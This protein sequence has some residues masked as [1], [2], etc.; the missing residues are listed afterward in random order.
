MSTRALAPVLHYLRHF[1]A[2]APERGGDDGQL[3]ERFSQGGDEAAFAAILKRY[4]PMVFGV[5]R[6]IVRDRHDAEDAF[7]ATFLLLVRKGA[8]LRQPHLLGHWLYGVAYRVALKAR[9]RAARCPAA[10]DL[11]DGLAAP[12]SEDAAWRD[13]GPLLDGAINAL[14]PRYRVPFVLCHIQGLTYAQAARRLRCPEGT[15]ATRLARARQRL[16][17]RLAKHGPA[18][19]LGAGAF[20]ASAASA[21]PPALL[22]VSTVRIGIAFRAGCTTAVPAAITGLTKG[23]STAMFTNQLRLALGL[24]L[25]AAATIG[26][27]A[28]GTLGAFGASQEP[29]PAP[30]LEPP[31]R[32]IVPH[33]PQVGASG[34]EPSRDG[35]LTQATERTPNFVVT[36]PNR[37]I[38]RLVGEAAERLRKSEAIRWLGK[39]LPTWFEPCAVNVQMRDRGRGHATTL[40]FERDR[41]LGRKMELE[42]TLEMVLANGLPHEMTHAVLADVFRAPI[43]RWADEGAAILAEDAEEQERHFALMRQFRSEPQRLIPLKRLLPMNE[44]PGNQTALL[45]VQGYTLTRFLVERKDRKTF[46]AFL[47]QGMSGDGWDIAVKDH[48]GFDDVNALTDA[49]LAYVNRTLTADARTPPPQ[50]IR[51]GPPHVGRARIDKDGRVLLRRPVSY[52]QPVT[53][54]TKDPRANTVT[55]VTSYTLVT[56]L[57]STHYDI[58]DIAARDLTGKPIDAKTLVQRLASDTAVLVPSSGREIDPFYLSV[59]KEGTMILL[60]R[61]SEPP[62]AEPPLPTA[63]PVMASPA[64]EPPLVDR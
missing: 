2:A 58:K 18:A 9:L 10:G 64:I 62:V 16:R 8:S 53:S 27:T 11:V 24:L 41:V 42:G 40:R 55:P 1:D 31:P 56:Q 63:P 6:R 39:E 7:Q 35:T 47:K 4:G 46:L 51:G 5:C 28:A 49:W 50:G 17:A 48:Y 20:T 43:P 30:A 45:Y 54:Y 36:G 37:R 13:L 38:V 57:Q 26:G 34:T 19:T 21:A 15:L 22:V 29:P 59:V 61:V 3:L 60:P 52:Y 12:A 33:V 25:L 32:A 14:P 23:V 44:F